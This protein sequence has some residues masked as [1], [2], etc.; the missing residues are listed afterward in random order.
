[1]GCRLAAVYTRP[2]NGSG[3]VN[4]NESRMV[5]YQSVPLKIAPVRE[6]VVERLRTVSCY[7]VYGIL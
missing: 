6:V 7:S 1:M 4:V 2:N 3:T 5:P